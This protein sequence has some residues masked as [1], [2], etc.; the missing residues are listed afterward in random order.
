MPFDVS[1]YP[2]NYY[3]YSASTNSDLVLLSINTFQKDLSDPSP[4]IRSMSLRVLTSIRVP[5]IQGM[6]DN[7]SAGKYPEYS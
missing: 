7:F 6:F 5:V 1:R 4:L 2:F 3:A